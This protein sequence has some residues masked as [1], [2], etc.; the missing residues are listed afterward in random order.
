MDHKL[1]KKKQQ[2]NKTQT[3]HTKRNQVIK[4]HKLS[5]LIIKFFTFI[6][7]LFIINVK[8]LSKLLYK[9]LNESYSIH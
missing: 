7:I 5:D 6:F 1:K 3:G 8:I 2:K 4:N 9:H